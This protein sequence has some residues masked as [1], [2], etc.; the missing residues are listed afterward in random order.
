MGETKE[1][2]YQCPTCTHNHN[3]QHNWESYHSHCSKGH[4]ILCLWQKERTCKDYEEGEAIEID[5]E[6]DEI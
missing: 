4:C 2:V 6:E 3:I 1:W 5:E